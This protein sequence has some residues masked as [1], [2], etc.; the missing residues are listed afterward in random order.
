MVEDYPSN[1]QRNRSPKKDKK[2]VEKVI[3]GE[4]IRRKKSLGKQFSETLG[5]GDNA[6]SVWSDIFHE[7]LIP[8]G[9]DAISDAVSQGLDRMLFG[10]SR[11]RSSA[12]AVSR[13]SGYV[14]YNKISSKREDPRMSTMSRRARSSHNFDEIVLE[15]RAAADE[16]LQAMYDLLSTYDVVSVADLYE[17]VGQTPSYTDEKWGWMDLRGS[18]IVRVKGGYL[19]DLPKTETLD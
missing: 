18:S 2:K 10:E 12:R 6:G 5:S 14:S 9:K 3:P 4:A 11:P 15:S 19:L 8:A 7:V 13:N 1:S 17:L 16:V